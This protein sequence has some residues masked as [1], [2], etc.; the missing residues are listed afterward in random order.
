M[1]LK[2]ANAQS[3]MGAASK[4][5]AERASEYVAYLSQKIEKLQKKNADTK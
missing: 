5:A 1:L 2:D 3:R 4:V